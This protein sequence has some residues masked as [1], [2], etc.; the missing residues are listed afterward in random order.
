MQDLYS[1]D[2][3]TPRIADDVLIAP[4]AR[5]IG[6]V[7]IG[8]RSSIW[9]NCVVR[10][11]VNMIRIGEGTNIQD[12]SVIHVTR[13]THGTFIGSGVLVGH[14][15]M[16]HGCE[17]ADHSFVGMGA[18]VMDGAC[19]ETDGMLA[20]GSL[21]TPGKVI[22]SR[23]LWAGRPAKYF[24]TLSDQDCARNRDGAAHYEKAAAL[25]RD[26]LKPVRRDRPDEYWV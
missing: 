5:V 4:G 1:I 21:L 2:G 22:P 26:G 18:M 19:I 17:L 12:G 3:K 25:Y 20:A 23:E 14:M 7:E 15:V 11:D 13:K 9:F 8:A 16:L 10:G 24:K 6:N